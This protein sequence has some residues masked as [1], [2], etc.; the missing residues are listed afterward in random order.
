MVEAPTA[1]RAELAGAGG[2]LT[3]SHVRQLCIRAVLAKA[4]A[5][6]E[7][8]HVLAPAIYVPSPQSNTL[9]GSVRGI[10]RRTDWVTVDV[11][12][13]RVSFTCTCGAQG[14]AQGATYLCPH[15]GALLL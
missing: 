1:A 4:S 10:W 14:A 7:A 15:A 2:A 13:S 6:Q 3:E 8:E 5:L 11:H 9:L 12:G